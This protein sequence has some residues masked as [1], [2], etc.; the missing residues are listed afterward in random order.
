[1]KLAL[2][3]ASLG[4]AALA[5]SG[6]KSGYALGADLRQLPRAGALPLVALF[7]ERAELAVVV[8]APGESWAA[9]QASPAYR[10]LGGELWQD[11]QALPP[12]ERWH[13]LQ[14]RLSE[15][16]RQPLPGLEGL[17]DAPSAL[18]FVPG[19][20]SGA[21]AGAAAGWLYVAK[22]D[23]SLP[24]VW[25]LARALNVVR[26]SARE[27]EVDRAD[28]LPLRNVSFGGG[29]RLTYALLGDRLIVASD[30][31]LAT[32]ALDLALDAGRHSLAG[33]APFSDLE[34]R[35]EVVGF[36]AAFLP[37]GKAAQLSGVQSLELD[38]PEVELKLDPTLWRPGSAGFESEAAVPAAL[39][40]LDLAGLDLKALLGRVAGEA[41]AHDDVGV[42]LAKLAA[43]AG[44]LGEGAFVQVQPW[45]SGFGVSVDAV[46]SSAAS[47]G[48]EETLQAAAQA[49]LAGVK[50]AEPLGS[51][52]L[53]CSEDDELCLEACPSALRLAWPGSFARTVG[54]PTL[55]RV[56]SSGASALGLWVAGTDGG[57]QLSVREGRGRLAWV[58]P[59]DVP[60]EAPK[61]VPK[62]FR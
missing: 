11:L 31:A 44:Q 14:A 50:P 49:L 2:G 52:T 1:M 61:A 62:E 46:R 30:S 59:Q 13:A 15:L 39:L 34:A 57:V 43:L 29:D 24:R 25:Q 36:A 47:P 41:T 5:C 33:H 9:L 35:A 53:W 12:V 4:I 28:G 58:G 27:V 20:A 37:Q 23:E 48:A 17:L 32:E 16:A 55:Q 10:A 38:G 40:R 26:P 56:P 18:A 45:Q 19:A 54:C 21:T 7:P 42:L 6:S 8:H 22:V 60:Q 51:A 3:L